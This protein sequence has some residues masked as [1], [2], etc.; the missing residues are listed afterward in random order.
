ML[1]WLLRQQGR[2]RLAFVVQ[3]AVAV[4]SR[5]S[6]GVGDATTTLILTHYN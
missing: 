4:A 5:G 6:I 3:V 2:D 1:R